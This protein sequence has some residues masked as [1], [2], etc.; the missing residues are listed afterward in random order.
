M[1]VKIGKEAYVE[2]DEVEFICSISNT[3]SRKLARESVDSGTA[4][5]CTS[6]K[7]KQT[8]I[9]TKS[10]RIYISPISFGTLRNK[11]FKDSNSSTVVD[12]LYGEEN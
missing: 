4:T 7:R 2:S 1:F 11:F 9:R 12:D 6:G 10:G 3:A 5:V 8:L